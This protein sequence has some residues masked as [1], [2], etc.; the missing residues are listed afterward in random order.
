MKP[1]IKAGIILGAGVVLWSL[2]FG[3]AGWYKDPGTTNLFLLVIPF[4]IGVIVWGLMQ[5]AKM[6]KR[7]GGQV[8]A[9]VMIALVGAVIIFLNSLVFTTVLFPEA[10]E[11]AKSMQAEKFAEQGMSD[12]QIDETME[13][14]AFAYTPVAQA[15]SGVIGTMMTG[16]FVSLIAAIFIRNKD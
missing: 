8:G 6:G 4:E 9:G 11:Y 16:L 1:T 2:V 5:T 10:T 3:F 12:Q 13:A 7:Y 15:I 14:M